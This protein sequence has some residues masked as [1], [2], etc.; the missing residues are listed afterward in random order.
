M[1]NFLDRC[2]I[3]KKNNWII[4]DPPLYTPRASLYSFS[5]YAQTFLPSKAD[6]L[7]VNECMDCS[8]EQIIQL[9]EYSQKQKCKLILSGEGPLNKEKFKNNDLSK[10]FI[11][12]VE[13]DVGLME[14]DNEVYVPQPWF[15]MQ[16][17]WSKYAKKMQWNLSNKKFISTMRCKNNYYPKML[18]YNQLENLDILDNFMWSSTFHEPSMKTETPKFFDSEI[19]LEGVN[20]ELPSIEQIMSYTHTV[21]ETGFDFIISEKIWQAFA[22]SQPVYWWTINDHFRLVEDYGFVT[23]F[24][25]ISTEYLKTTDYSKRAQIL[26]SELKKLVDEPDLARELYVKNE[27]IAKHNHALFFDVKL[28]QDAGLN[29]IQSKLN[30]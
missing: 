1:E 26:A 21:I 25:G 14:H 16:H 10:E 23:E 17:G 5:D 27:D 2:K 22:F 9:V 4:I 24:E 13:M 28:C 8:Y 20:A 11:F 18:L 3:V 19:N 7:I 30:I 12:A 15:R 29:A 6:L